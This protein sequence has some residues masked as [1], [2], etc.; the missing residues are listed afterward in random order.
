MINTYIA[1]IRISLKQS[2]QLSIQMS[3]IGV[4]TN[5]IERKARR[6]T[7]IRIPP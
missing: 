4:K 3:G 1:H 5:Q 6:N 2:Y 7:A